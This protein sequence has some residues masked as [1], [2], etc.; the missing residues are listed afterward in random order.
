[1]R[2][3]LLNSR[4]LM[5]S[6]DTYSLRGICMLMII[7]HHV[8][9][10]YPD[11][12][13]SI[14]RWGYLGV[15]VFF[16]ISGWGMYCSM[17]RQ[18]KVTWE[19]FAKQM[20]KLLIPYA[21]IWPLAEILYCAQ[22]V[23]YLSAFGLLR[24]F[25]TLTFPP[26]PSMWFLKV[27]VVAY[28]FAIIT[29]ILVNNRLARLVIVSFFSIVYYVVAWKIL[30]LPLYWYGTSLCIAA[31]LWMAAYREELSRIYS[32]KYALLIGGIILYYVSFHYNVL[33]LPSRTIHSFA[34]AIAMLSFI[35]II[36]IANPILDYIGR[37]SLLFYLVHVS[38]CELLPPPLGFLR[39]RW[40]ALVFILIITAILTISYNRIKIKLHK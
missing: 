36:S 23:D 21:I 18:E 40:M 13:E 2:Y 10:L 33:P 38:L 24:D 35:S 17:E 15:A 31:G 22:H 29:F 14:M 6:Q 7:I 39:Q 19:Y 20:K 37:N 25:F 27:I 26:F 30:K 4:P 8:F 32:W 28:A 5:A 1:M 12:P 16:V 3:K 34:F 9:K 11:C